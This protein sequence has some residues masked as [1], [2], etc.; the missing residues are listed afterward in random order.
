MW[1]NTETAE[2][3]ACQVQV[4]IIAGKGIGS[5]KCPVSIQEGIVNGICTIYQ[6]QS[7]IPGAEEMNSAIREPAVRLLNEIV[8]GLY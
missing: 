5:R 3:G 1:Y 6:G 7:V 8:A 4:I 2:S